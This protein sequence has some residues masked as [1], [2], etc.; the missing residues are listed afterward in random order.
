MKRGDGRPTVPSPQREPQ[1]VAASFVALTNWSTPSARPGA[2]G[3]GSRGWAMQAAP[4]ICGPDG[5]HLTV[6]ENIIFVSASG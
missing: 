4:R 1:C 5:Y 2:D 3:A 6:T